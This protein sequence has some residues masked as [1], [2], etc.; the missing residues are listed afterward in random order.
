[1]KTIYVIAFVAMGYMLVT[2]PE[3]KKP[4]SDPLPAHYPT[5]GKGKP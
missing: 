4:A 5:K 1:M 3:E 2:N